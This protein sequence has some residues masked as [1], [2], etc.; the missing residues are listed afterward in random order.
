[1]LAAMHSYASDLFIVMIVLEQGK[2]KDSR[3]KIGGE[4]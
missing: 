4:S 3:R 2:R 1:M